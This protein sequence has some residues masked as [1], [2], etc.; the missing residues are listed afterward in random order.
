MGKRKMERIDEMKDWLREE[1]EELAKER[2]RKM[3]A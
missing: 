3:K 1:K 2:I